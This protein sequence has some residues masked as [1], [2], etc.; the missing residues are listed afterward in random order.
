[1]STDPVLVD[2]VVEVLHHDND[3]WQVGS[4]FV[5]RDG[6]V[7]T[8]AHVAG[9][10]TLLV[11]F[12][13]DDER[14]A[15]LCRL[16]SGRL[17][18]DETADLALIEFDGAHR[19]TAVAFAVLR[20]DPTLVM[21]NL[22][23][24]VAF[25]FPAFA[26]KVRPWRDKPVREVVRVDGYVPMGEGAI[27]GLATLRVP[28]AP[29]DAPI[30]E[31]LLAESSWQGI[32]GAVVFAGGHAIGVISEHHR[33]AGVNG[34]TVIPLSRLDDVE[35]STSWWE[36]LGVA[37]RTALPRLPAEVRLEVRQPNTDVEQR[38]R[39]LVLAQPELTV[40]SSPFG[41]LPT[42]F[43]QPRLLSPVGPGGEGGLVM[44]PDVVHA[45]DRLVIIGDAGLGKTTL[46]HEIA[47]RMASGDYSGI[48]LFLR[49]HD[50]GRR[51]LDTDLLTFAVTE[52]FGG[53][54]GAA[55]ITQVVAFLREREDV[56]FLFDG[57]DEVPVGQLDDV[58][59]KVRRTRRFVLTTRP[60]SR[61]DVVQT[62]GA[63]YRITELTDG[64]VAAFVQRWV[65][66]EPRAATLQ[67]RIAEDL[68]MADLARLPQLLVLL[69]WMWRSTSA[70]FHTRVQ[71]LAGAVEEA[72]ARAVRISRLAEG[73]EEVVPWQ[74]RRA[75]RTLALEVACADDG[76]VLTFT[77][78]RLLDLLAEEGGRDRASALFAFTRR[79]GL[80]VPTGGSGDELQFLHSLFRT[81][82][83][84]E[85]LAGQRD[86]T[87]RVD[88]FAD[89]VAG[90]DVLVAAAS[91]DPRRMPA[92][93]LDRAAAREPDIFRMN[94]WLAALCMGGVHDQREVATPLRVVA[95]EV[96][97]AACE[98][99]SRDRFAPVL[100]CLRTDHVRTLLLN[101]LF[102]QDM[103]VRWASALALDHRR[104]A[105]AVP[106]LL[107]Q[108]PD[109]SEPA[110]R[111]AIIG[112]LGRLR[113]RS[114]LPD[115]WRE[116]E[117]R[118]D[119]R[120]ISEHRTIGESLARLG[121]T[122]ELRQLVNRAH[123]DSVI[124]VLLGSVPFLRQ[125]V[126]GEVLDAL[127]RQRVTTSTEH[128]LQQYLDDLDDLD[129][130]LDRKHNALNGLEGVDGD[131][132]VDALLRTAT[133]AEDDGLRDHAA[134]VLLELPDQ[135]F[136]QMVDYLVTEFWRAG[137]DRE[138][139]A[140]A[141]VALWSSPAADV[142]SDL[143]YPPLDDD[144]HDIDEDTHPWAWVAALL[145]AVLGGEDRIEP[146]TSL[147][148]AEGVPVPVAAIAVAAT[149]GAAAAAE[150]IADRLRV[151]RVGRVRVACLSALTRLAP[152]NAAEVIAPSLD[153]PDPEE[154]LLAVR[155]LTDLG[156]IDLA[157]LTTRLGTESDPQ[158]QL[159]II[160]AL[161]QGPQ[162]DAVL[163][164]LA[165]ELSNVDADVRATAARA[166]GEAGMTEYAPRLREM[167]SADSKREA[168]NAAE[169]YAA[170]ATG[171]DL[172]AIVD[173]MVAT[174]FHGPLMLAVA[175][176]LACRPELVDVLTGKI[177]ETG[178]IALGTSRG[179]TVR[180]PNNTY[181]VLL[182][183]DRDPAALLDA[184]T[185]PDPGERWRA[186][187]AMKPHLTVRGAIG[188][189]GLA[190]LDE[191]ECVAH[192][193]E[194]VLEDFQ[195]NYTVTQLDDRSL[196]LLSAPDTFARLADRLAQGDSAELVIASLLEQREFLPRLLQAYA[197][198][199][200][201][202]R[203]VLWNL[204]DRHQ[205]RLFAD[206]TALLPSGEMV[207]WAELPTV[208][209]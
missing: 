112:A 88:W 45:V 96:F 118:A 195:D 3:R 192:A 190:L 77:R 64:G 6:I 138:L 32:S 59:A 37:D 201:E 206:G 185:D 14:P 148:G 72:M 30:L 11:R 142:L 162:E 99:W 25:G 139:F 167:M 22:R 175:S 123:Q 27:E 150:P 18:L 2:Q 47:R 205:L 182:D 109:E 39:A 178:G 93:I 172:I 161:R 131:A 133:F 184:I 24:C 169:A 57:L 132:V 69:C 70:G 124:E 120:S 174:S 189:V 1:M 170:V 115:L 28:D 127:A 180:Y 4:G 116:F 42:E 177:E 134:R 20:D 126:R 76:L 38:L 12:R 152:E 137:P 7:L 101:G 129:A 46:L 188:A 100:G 194:S 153:A 81:F 202:L 91:L 95:D 74:V 55:E 141:F 66:R 48:P 104:D 90:H 71:I 43:F 163:D 164:A 44:L 49:L 68:V 35:D 130:T 41:G 208:A 171:D 34:L 191:N 9:E 102:D 103:Y 168:N 125:P 140:Y 65:V 117:K 75:L 5:V 40:L 80:V 23:D 207:S 128:H 67:D 56:V 92:L 105:D 51:G 181:N 135:G 61:V 151:E 183:D 97:A 111:R 13:G 186:V 160:D 158:V 50:L 53:M 108:L 87:P 146:L 159:T 86:P 165:R 155:S 83:A 200:P 21:P 94:S 107:A 144:V 26:E 82:L 176:A 63:T 166:V 33:P 15:R 157:E 106:H 110:V 199:R 149:V 79:T 84:G 193:A 60:M 58:L 62:S 98:W 89:R 179:A 173:E 85:A 29:R 36:L 16:P 114:A 31:G 187:R 17:A 196:E 197:D 122:R 203:Q 198:G 154:R 136:V 54:L 8:A 147:I 78:G 113:D 143:S 119:D 209:S 145:L 73:D 204:A 52:Q 156:A 19:G 10:G 121:A